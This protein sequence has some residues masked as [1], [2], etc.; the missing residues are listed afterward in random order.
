MKKYASECV[1]KLFRHR[2]LLGAAS[3]VVSY[4]GCVKKELIELLGKN[5]VALKYKPIMCLD[6]GD[7]FGME[8]YVCWNRSPAIYLN[9][10]TDD[11]LEVFDSYDVCLPIEAWILQ[12]ALEQAAIWNKAYGRLVVAFNIS[13]SQLFNENFFTNVNAAC[14]AT[15]LSADLIEF[16]IAEGKLVQHPNRIA[17]LMDEFVRRGWGLNVDGF[18]LSSFS[19]QIL[20]HRA[21]KKVKF[22]SRLISRIFSDEIIYNHVKYMGELALSNGIRLAADGITSSNIADA[23]T[24]IGCGYGQGYYFGEPLTTTEFSELLEG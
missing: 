14:E 21:L 7:V 20:E 16:E 1:L 9:L 2:S 6:T 22:S 18:G 4:S 10:A 15:S 3:N 5:G 23:A 11:F 13:L 24:N 19:N 12:A 8:V 17:A